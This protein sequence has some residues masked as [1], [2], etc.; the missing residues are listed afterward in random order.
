MAS[1]LLPLYLKLFI[2]FWAVAGYGHAPNHPCPRPRKRHK[3]SLYMGLTRKNKA[4]DHPWQWHFTFLID[5]ISKSYSPQETHIKEGVRWLEYFLLLVLSEE[6]LVLYVPY[7]GDSVIFLSICP[8]IHS[9][10]RESMY[11][12]IYVWISLS[13]FSLFLFIY[14]ANSLGLK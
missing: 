13:L 14:H 10:T 12:W 2:P 5:N 1:L 9:S 6:E 4:E 8:P 11:L 3:E 7:R